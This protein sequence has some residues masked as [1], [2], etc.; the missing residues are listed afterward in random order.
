MKSYTTLRTNYGVDTKNT[1]AANLTIGDGWM[2][3][4]IRRLLAKA[5]WP[6]LHRLRTMTTFAPSSTITAA[7]TGIITA[8]D[9]VVQTLTGTKVS[10]STTDTLPSGLSTSTTYYMI[11][12]SS[13]TFKVATTLANAMAGT[14]VTIADTGTGTHTA[15]MET[16]SQ[17]IPYDVDQIESVFVTVGTTR[18][19]PKPAPSRSF[20]DKLHYSSVNSDTPEYWFIQDGALELWPYPASSGNVISMNSKIKVRDLNI[21]DVTTS[22]ITTLANG[23]RALTLSAGLTVQMTGFWIRPTFTTTTNTGDG[24]WYELDYISSTTAGMLTTPYGG[25]SISGGTAACTIGQMPLLPEAF[26]DLPE[27]YAAY[28]YWLK[29]KDMERASAFKGMVNEGIADLFKTYGVND[30]SMVLD[31]G[32]DNFILNPNLTISL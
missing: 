6:F 22:T 16:L 27:Q 11:Y 31:D 13:T 2:N 30:L 32:E 7:V 28:R 21:A 10:F 9:A 25:V 26:H 5:D 3:D 1:S 19:N 20:W 23:D 4:F 24:H 12:Q 8:T 15:V 18:Y 29:E 17:P 14:A